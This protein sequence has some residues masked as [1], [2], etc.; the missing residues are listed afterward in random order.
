MDNSQSAIQLGNE[1]NSILNASGPAPVVTGASTQPDSIL[2]LTMG[3]LVF[4]SIFG[5][6]G[7]AYLVYAKKQGHLSAG[8][9]GIGLISYTFVVTDTT[10]IILIGAVLTVLPF[11]VA[12][13]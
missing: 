11:L 9:C 7:M 1:I 8:L 3:G 10:L 6:I 5:L 4:G 12:R 2:G 13:R